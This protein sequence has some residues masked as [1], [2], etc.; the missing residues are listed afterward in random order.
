MIG[1]G[2][3]WVTELILTYDGLPPYTMNAMEILGG[4]VARQTQYFGG[5]FEPGPSRA[6]RVERME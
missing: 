4:K 3:L 5:P 1:T 2:D 6:Q